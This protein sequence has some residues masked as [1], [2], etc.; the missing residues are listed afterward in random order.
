MVGRDGTDAERARDDLGY[1]HGPF[2]L[3]YPRSAVIYKLTASIAPPPWV[4]ISTPISEHS[5]T[6]RHEIVVQR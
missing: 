2:Q 4:S 3:P 6:Y 1:G 5:A